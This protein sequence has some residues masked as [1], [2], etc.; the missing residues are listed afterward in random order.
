MHSVFVEA[1]LNFQSPTFRCS[2][3]GDKCFR[4]AS[5]LMFLIYISFV[6]GVL[7]I[8]I[9]DFVLYSEHVC[10]F[11]L[12][13]HLIICQIWCSTLTMTSVFSFPNSDCGF[14]RIGRAKLNDKTYQ[15]HQYRIIHIFKCPNISPWATSTKPHK[16]NWGSFIWFLNNV[17]RLKTHFVAL[18][19]LKSSFLKNGLVF[20]YLWN[21]TLSIQRL[22]LT[23]GQYTVKVS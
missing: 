1:K 3:S 16:I 21:F 20:E 8:P 12:V 13:L 22:R 2:R 23:Q 17:R 9:F 5:W 18:A 19:R 6:L 15:F 4:V 10:L 11:P 7:G 14:A